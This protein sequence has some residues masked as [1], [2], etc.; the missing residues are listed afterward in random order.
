MLR[1]LLVLPL[2]VAPDGGGFERVGGTHGVEVYRRMASPFIDLLAQGEIDAPPGQVRD[3]LL[4]YDDATRTSDHVAESRILT[5]QERSLIVYQRL[6]LPII[7]DRD[8][9]QRVIWQQRGS[10]LLIRFAVDNGRGPAP[11]DGIVRVPLL[12]GGWD[13]EPIRDGQATRARYHVQIDLSGS[14]PMWMV[15]GGAAKDLPKLFEGVR[16][17]ARLRRVVAV[18]YQK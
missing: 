9:T 4:D 14:V 13:L 12:N 3:A 2:L 8:Y 10:A 18:D 1:L 7:A 15:S 5:R 16:R 6:R 17:Q 11:R